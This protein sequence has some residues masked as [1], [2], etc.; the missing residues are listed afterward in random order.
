[1][2]WTLKDRVSLMRVHRW[3]ALQERRKSADEGAAHMVW[4]GA[5]LNV[6]VRRVEVSGR[7]GCSGKLTVTGKWKYSFRS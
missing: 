7:S 5:L 6:F 3:K 2:N 1:M 4:T